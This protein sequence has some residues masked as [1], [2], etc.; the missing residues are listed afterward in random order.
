MRIDSFSGSDDQRRRAALD[1]DEE[2]FEVF[3]RRVS[4]AEKDDSQQSDSANQGRRAMGDVLN[5]SRT[6]V[7]VYSLGLSYRS[8]R[9][10]EEPGENRRNQPE[11]SP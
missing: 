4:R 10:R 3:G 8:P 6:I 11:E 2:D 1:V 5:V 7:G 9:R